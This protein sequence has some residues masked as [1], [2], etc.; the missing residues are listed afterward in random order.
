MYA[1]TGKENGRVGTGERYGQDV[2]EIEE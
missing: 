1:R 2:E